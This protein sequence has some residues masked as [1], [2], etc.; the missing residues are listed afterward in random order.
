MLVLTRQLGQEVIIDGEIRN[1]RIV[2]SFR[3]VRLLTAVTAEC[4]T[5]S[6]S[7][8]LNSRTESLR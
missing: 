7:K 2:R 5:P 4:T 8:N 6:F 3:K 1:S